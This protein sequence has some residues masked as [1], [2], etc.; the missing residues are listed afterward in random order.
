M[1]TFRTLPASI[2]IAAPSG[3]ADIPVEQPPN[4]PIDSSLNAGPGRVG[5]R[6]GVPVAFWPVSQHL[7]LRAGFAV[8]LDFL[9]PARERGIA[10][11]GNVVIQ[12]AG[13]VPVVALGVGHTYTWFSGLSWRPSTKG[14]RPA[15]VPYRL[16]LQLDQRLPVTMSLLSGDT[17]PCSSSRWHGPLNK[18]ASLDFYAQGKAANPGWKAQRLLGGVGEHGRAGAVAAAKRYGGWNLCLAIRGCWPGS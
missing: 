13:M 10:Q 5:R 16:V 11:S 9:L 6:R 3:V 14:L 2:G 4:Q 7:P 8:V 18:Q 15:T 17:H 12:S 1:S